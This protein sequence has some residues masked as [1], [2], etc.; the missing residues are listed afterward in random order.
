MNLLTTSPCITAPPL[1][2]HHTKLPRTSFIAFVDAIY[3]G[4]VPMPRYIRCTVLQRMF[5]PFRHFL[6]NEERLV[7]DDGPRT[8]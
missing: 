7:L 8:K 1:P 4:R 6:F 2:L 5:K 3:G